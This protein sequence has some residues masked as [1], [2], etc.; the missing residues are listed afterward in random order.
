MDRDI[1]RRNTRIG[2][3]LGAVCFG[4]FGLSFVTALVYNAA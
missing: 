4:M 1:A 3:A 2:L